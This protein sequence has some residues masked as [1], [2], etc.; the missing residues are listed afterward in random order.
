MIG[1]LAWTARAGNIVLPVN[2]DSG[3]IS[4]DDQNIPAITASFT[5]PRDDAFLALA[6]PRQEPAPRIQL[7][8]HLTEWQ[9]LPLSAMSAYWQNLGGTVAD[10]SAAW[11]GLQLRDVSNMFGA[12]LYSAASDVPTSMSLDLHVR[13]LTYDDWEMTISVA[14]DEALLIDW[15]IANAEDYA[16][17][18]GGQVGMNLQRVQAYVDPVLSAILGY[19]TD[20]NVYTD[21]PL[22]GPWADVIQWRQDMTGWDLIRLALEDTDLKLRVNPSGRGFTLQRPQNS[23]N[24]PA[25]H[26]FLFTGEDVTTVKHTRS[27]SEDWYDSAMLSQGDGVDFTFAAYPPSGRHSRTYVERFPDGTKLTSSMAENIVRRSL[28]RGQFIDIVAPI[29]LG[30]FMRDEFAYAPTLDDDAEQWI[31]KS[32][33]YDIAAAQMNIRGEQR[34]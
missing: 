27:R 33:S 26:A 12:P 22:S 17:I 6:D 32:V 21:T 34:Y 15:A 2:D 19:T 14:S 20:E 9:S 29:R 4:I 31:V 1:R 16:N 30:V 5:V 7:S 18:I 10:L 13:T 28:N 11:T 25:E 23:I 24:N 3:T 8:G